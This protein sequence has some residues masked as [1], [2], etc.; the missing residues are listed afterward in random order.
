MCNLSEVVIRPDDNLESL[1]RKVRL[2][3]ILG[4]LQSTLTDFRYLRKKWKD[5]CEEERL[6]G[7]SLTGICDN[8]LMNDSHEL[9][10]SGNVLVELREHSVKVNKE[11]AEKLGINQSTAICCVKPS[12][13]VSQLVDS[14]SGIHPRFAPYY[15]R[16]VRNDKKDPLSQFMIDE[17]FLYEEDVMNNQ[18]YVF[19]FPM[20]SPVGAETTDTLT[21]MQ[22]LDLWKTYAKYWCEHKPS[23]T[24]YYN[25]N[26][27]LEMGNWIWNNFDEV[28]GVSFLPKSDHTYQQAP[29]EEITEEECEEML[30][31]MPKDV[32]W[33][34]L[35]LYENDDHTKGTQE[36]ACTGGACEIA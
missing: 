31:K 9:V 14:A 4:T 18:T 26:D 35:A 10:Y 23:M 8:S 33:S 19:S 3:T 7:V 12:G 29:Y 2:A 28:S 17:G 36:L 24:A 22:Q 1:K 5:N 6:L 11:Y 34:R 27:F 21:G 16:R 20:K 15:I 13:T 32:D 25:D 30:A